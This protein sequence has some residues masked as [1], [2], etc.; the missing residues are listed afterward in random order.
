MSMLR[1]AGESARLLRSQWIYTLLVMLTCAVSVFAAVAASGQGIANERRVLASIDEA[2]TTTIRVRDI[3]GNAGLSVATVDRIVSLSHVVWAVGFGP[4]VD[5]ANARLNSAPDTPVKLLVGS[6]PA[7]N[8]TGRDGVGAWL[9]SGAAA[10][11][12]MAQ[13]AGGIRRT[14]GREYAVLGEFQPVEPLGNL[15]GLALVRDAEDRSPLSEIVVSVS[16]PGA[17]AAVSEAVRAVAG[18]ASP[19]SIS[20]DAPEVLADVRNVVAGD[21]RAQGQRSTLAVLV[22]SSAMILVVAFAAVSAR[23]R[24]FGRRR[25]LGARRGN[26]AALIVGHIV[27]ASLVGSAVGLANGVLL[28]RAMTQQPVDLAYPAA[29]SILTIVTSAVSGL[30]PAVVAAMRD[31]LKVLRSA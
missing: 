17:V 14:D 12:H 31:P 6:S 2:D 30:G 29:T 27:L 5:A 16:K 22:F 19:A 25:A 20:I 4:A 26:L 8:I 1:V 11:L 10:Q 21:L 18:H 9:S 3:D 24:D 7:L 15:A 13:A 23:R 28:V